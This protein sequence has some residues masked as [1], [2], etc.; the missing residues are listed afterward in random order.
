M[1]GYLLRVTAAAILSSLITRLA[2]K[3]ASGRGARMAAGLLVLVAAFAP[4]GQ[5]NTL[6]AARDLARQI[7]SDPLQ[8]DFLTKSNRE[9]MSSLISGEAEAY[10]LDKAQ[11]L[12]FAPGVTV[13]VAVRDHYPVPWSVTLEG[14]MTPE[15]KATL[16][17][18]IEKEL[19][20]PEERQEWMTKESG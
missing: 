4:L 6:D 20:I 11:A 16:G 8:T 13:M 15:Q 1:K 12:G 9:L 2:P 5:I 19:D 10:I 14:E 7:R 18:I 3:G 17:K